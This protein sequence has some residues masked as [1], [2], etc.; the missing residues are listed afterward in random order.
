MSSD[1]RAYGR[2]WSWLA[3]VARVQQPFVHPTADRALRA[4]VAFRD[5][6]VAGMAD[7]PHQGQAELPL[8]PWAAQ[9]GNRSRDKAVA[10]AR[11]GEERHRAE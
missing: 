10:R 4:P 2:C 1:G 7:N 11:L 8:S 3:A 9:Q 6:S 5:P